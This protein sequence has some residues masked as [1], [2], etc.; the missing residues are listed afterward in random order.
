M[1]RFLLAVPLLVGCAAP[2]KTEPESPAPAVFGL[3]APEAERVSVVGTFNGWDPEAH[4]LQGPD[5]GG[6][7]SLRLFLPPGR[8]RYMFVVDGVRWVTDPNAAVRE[9][10]GFG[11]YNSVLIHGR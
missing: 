2:Q 11:G 7:W 3:K 10:D 6:V 8:H 5:R 4:P 9:E 1:S